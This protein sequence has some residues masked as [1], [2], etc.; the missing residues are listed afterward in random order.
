MKL[1]Y[2]RRSDG[3]ENFGDLLNSWLFPKLLTGFFDEDETVTFIGFGTLLNHRLPCRI[4]RSQKLIIFSTGAGYEKPLTA[5]PDSWKIYCVRGPLSARKLGISEEY[6]VTDGGILVR[7]FFQPTGR[8]VSSFSFMPHINHACAAGDSWETI[9][10]QIGFQYIDPRWSVERVLESISQTEVLLTEAMHGAIVADALR[11]PWLS[12]ITRPK[13]LQFKWHDWCLSVGLKYRPYYLP[14]LLDSYPRY[15]RG[16]RSSLSS[17]QHWG[18]ALKQNGFQSLNVLKD[19]PS[20]YLAQQLLDIARTARP[21]LSSDEQI[22][23][24][25][26]RLENRLYQLTMNNE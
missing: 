9:C 8:K 25:S 19:D 17:F 16:F 4:S 5:I 10:R 22:E 23:Q 18:N 11:V 1:F 14:P 21:Q 15:A 3:V 2:Y 12:I 26:E 13:I 6:A 7:R 24:L 20:Q